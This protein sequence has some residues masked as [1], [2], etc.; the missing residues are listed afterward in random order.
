MRNIS[1]MAGV[2]AMCGVILAADQAAAP[3][4]PAGPTIT[5]S[6]LGMIR[7]REDIIQNKISG[8]SI[9]DSVLGSNK[10]SNR[11]AYKFGGKFKVNDQVTLQ[12]EIGNEWYATEEV[13]GGNYLGNKRNMYA[14]MFLLGFAQW[15]P[16]FLHIQAGLCPVKGSAVM[17]LI[18]Y[19]LRFDKKYYYAPTGFHPSHLPWGVTA[20]FMH[21][22]L[23]FGV[24]ILKG[25][26]KLGI[27]VF[28]GVSEMRQV[29]AAIK[30]GYLNN[31]TAV[32]NII[33]IPFSVAGL[34]LTPQVVVIANRSVKD[35]NK[36]FNNVA[37]HEIAGGFDVGYKL[38]DIVN[39][40][41]GFGYAYIANTNTYAA[42]DSVLKVPYD[43]TQGKAADTLYDRRGMNI[44]AGSTIKAGP[45]KIDIDFNFGTNEDKAVTT[46]NLGM[47]QFFDLKYGW[48]VNKNFIIMPRVRVYLGE[49]EKGVVG[50]DV[51]N[52][53]TW[54]ELMIFGMF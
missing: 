33:D 15:D 41:A 20:N 54:P 21:P 51:F 8:T 16:G 50:K 13:A 31:N 2:L 39:F 37:D 11:L 9:G 45:G 44:T 10:Y 34:T 23:R 4:V 38:N 46:D 35:N 30:D 17:D 28:S 24:P 22:G 32:M 14:P 7:F 49:V 26:V 18:G 29:K 27:D 42:G 47:F 43:A 1:A 5:W 40:R 6:G 52:F 53:R 19:S 25:D 12:F 36:T 48:A 3:A